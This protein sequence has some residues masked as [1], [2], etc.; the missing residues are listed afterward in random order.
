MNPSQ[1]AIMSLDELRPR[2]TLLGV[3]TTGVAFVRPNIFSDAW[4]ATVGSMR[5]I[6]YGLR[7]TKARCRTRHKIKRNR[8]RGLSVRPRGAREL[9]NTRIVNARC[10]DAA[11]MILQH[12]CA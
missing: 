10:A 7:I 12:H 1:T 3:R 6:T 2:G 11:L 4:R 9:D 8:L 5:G